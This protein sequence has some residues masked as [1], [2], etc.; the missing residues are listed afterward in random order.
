MKAFLNNVGTLNEVVTVLRFISR[1]QTEIKPENLIQSI[2]QGMVNLIVTKTKE[3]KEDCNLLQPH[4]S[5][6]LKD[7]D[8]NS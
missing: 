7:A 5:I 8:I 2:F 4:L 1:S 3:N 6:C